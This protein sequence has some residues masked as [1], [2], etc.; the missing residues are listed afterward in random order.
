MIC[1]TPAEDAEQAFI[2]AAQACSQGR[3]KTIIITFNKSYSATA[4]LLARASIDRQRFTVIA[5]KDVSVVKER[6]ENCIVLRDPSSLNDLGMTVSSLAAQRRYRFIMLD[7]VNALLFYNK[8]S[9]ARRFME[10]LIGI[11]K[12]YG[13][14][15][16]ML[17]VDEQ[18][19]RS[20]VS[21]MSSLC[22]SAL[23][24]QRNRAAERF[25]EAFR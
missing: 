12:E 19:S 3:G 4:R 17:A 22:D 5:C 20:A 16:V 6:S 13:L 11:V 25:A 21:A 8:E 15:G 24:L 18:L 10:M 2:A 23:R 7:S 1:I 9:S 14:S